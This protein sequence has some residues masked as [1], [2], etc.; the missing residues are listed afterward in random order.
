MA[1][2]GFPPG[3]PNAQLCVPGLVTHPALVYQDRSHCAV[4]ELDNKSSASAASL[5][6]GEFQAVIK[7][8]ASAASPR[9][10]SASGQLDHGLKNPSGKAAL[11]AD[12]I[13]G[14]FIFLPRLRLLLLFRQPGGASE[15]IQW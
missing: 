2:C 13:T 8:A 6:Y 15:Q 14:K 7:S 5:D 9:G 3:S 11:S 4:R 10:G 1:L 12:S